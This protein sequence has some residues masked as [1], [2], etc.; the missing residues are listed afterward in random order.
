MKS[1]LEDLTVTDFF[2]INIFNSLVSN[3]KYQIID[4]KSLIKESYELAV[5][6]NELH[7][8]KLLNKDVSKDEK[9]T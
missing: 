5:F 4:K 3:A 9:R 6:M 1:V 8:K 2:A 7:F